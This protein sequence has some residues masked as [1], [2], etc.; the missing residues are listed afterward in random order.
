MSALHH[1]NPH[2]HWCG[3][4]KTYNKGIRNNKTRYWCTYCLRYFSVSHKQKPPLLWISYIDGVPLRKLG[5]EINLSPSRTYEKVFEELVKL[6]D[7]TWVSQQYCNRYSGILILDGK[8]IKVKGYPQKIPFIYG[9]DYLTHDIPVGI[10][11]PSENDESFKKYFRLLKTCGYPLQV[12]VGDDR[13]SL[14][15]ALFHYYP[16][17]KTQLC[18]NHYVE[19]IR[20]T[21]HVRTDSKYHH[22]FN[23]LYKHLFHYKH[24]DK[25]LSTAFH[26]LL[27]NRSNNDLL[28]QT[29][30]MDIYRKRYQ[31]FAYPK[32]PHCP[33]D[34]NLVELYNSHLQARLKSI[35]GFKSFQHAET[36]KNA[37][38]LR[39]RTKPLTDCDTKF[40]KL[41]GKCSFELS[42][43]KG[44]DWPEI[45]NF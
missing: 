22:F 45:L 17:A 38:L 35:K 40:R 23:S 44:I 5:D 34:S 36:W 32:F 11:A 2:C 14:N 29:I 41:N 28:L 42:L 27:K 6:P 12:V 15:R 25:Y 37:Y 3:S 13:V 8:Y 16:N 33:K 10:L 20:Q 9:I 18:H 26:H 4:K 30:L 7:N 24:R 1:E 39:R 31:L 21:L 43:R 19:N